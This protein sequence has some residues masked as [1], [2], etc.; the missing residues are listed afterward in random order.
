[1]EQLSKKFL[2]LN[3]IL[4]QSIILILGLILY[5]LFYMKNGASWLELFTAASLKTICF[6]TVT[7]STILGVFQLIFI[8]FVSPARLYDEINKQIFEKF[9]YFEL[10]FIFLFGAWAEELLFRAVIQPF[11]GVWLTSLIFMVIHFRY[12]KKVYAL[13]EVYLLSVVLGWL[14]IMTSSLWVPV[15]CHF[16]VN[17]VMAVLAKN[18]Y[19]KVPAE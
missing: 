15:I 2:L 5:W 3:L 8:K 9:S 1:M 17:Y 13:F 12:L 6:Y 4:S 7:G 19:F 16:T 18:G 14:Y 11:L 10:L